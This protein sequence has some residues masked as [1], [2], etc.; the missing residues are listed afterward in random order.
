MV[1]SGINTIIKVIIAEAR[2]GQ[3]TVLK[4]SGKLEKL[5]SISSINWFVKV[6]ATVIVFERYLYFSHYTG[7]IY[8]TL[9]Y[10]LIEPT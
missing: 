10:P 9:N 3:V 7:S 5:K 2:Q 8:Y 4:H 6:I 1:F